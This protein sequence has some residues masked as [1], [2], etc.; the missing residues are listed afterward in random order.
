M[1]DVCCH[2]NL[3]G[4]TK[5]SLAEFMVLWEWIVVVGVKK[6]W[7]IAGTVDGLLYSLNDSE[8]ILNLTTFSNFK[9]S[10]I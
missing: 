2:T 9:T 6:I 5:L 1:R 4:V 10:R 3:I 7:K 8:Q